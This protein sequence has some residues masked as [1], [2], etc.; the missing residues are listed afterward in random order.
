MLSPALV[1]APLPTT[2]CP[3]VAPQHRRVTPRGGNAQDG[4]PLRRPFVG[5]LLLEL[6]RG[7]SLAE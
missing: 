6:G 2:G 3:S 5:K 4:P 1:R 7:L